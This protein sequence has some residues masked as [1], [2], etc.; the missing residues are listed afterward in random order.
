MV[1]LLEEA[2]G[3]DLAERT[4]LY[5]RGAHRLTSSE[6]RDL[7]VSPLSELGGL[8]AKPATLLVDC[9]YPTQEQVTALG[10]GAYVEVVGELREQRR[11]ALEQLRPEA[12]VSLSSGAAKLFADGL[13]IPERTKVYGE[14]KWLDERQ[15]LEDCPELGVRL[16]IARIYAASGPHMTKASSYALGDLIE[17]ARAGGAIEIRAPHRVMRSY[18]L[19]ADTLELAVLAS[20]GTDADRPELFETGGEQVDLAELARRVSLVVRGEEPELLLAEPDGSADDVYLG[21][22]S[23]IAELADLH[24]LHLAGL[25]EQ[26]LRTA[27]NG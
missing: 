13:P 27:E 25:D 6:G 23:R 9:A 17:Q 22:P 5:A 21:D 4:E 26:I 20:L 3:A 10:P 1:D 8:S 12:F 2:Y 7:R 11:T 18:T 15:M 16:C 19:A 24:G 14:M